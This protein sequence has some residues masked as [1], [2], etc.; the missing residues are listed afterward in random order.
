MILKNVYV[1]IDKLNF[2]IRNDTIAFIF[3]FIDQFSSIGLKDHNSEEIEKK[4][5]FTELLLNFLIFT[6]IS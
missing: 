5:Q 1:K 3:K 6:E 2:I 4:G